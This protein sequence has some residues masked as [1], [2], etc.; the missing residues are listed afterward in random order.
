M[1]IV[2]EALL[3][4]KFEKEID[5]L[6][7]HLK[8][9]IERAINIYKN[10][11]IEELLDYNKNYELQEEFSSPFKSKWIKSIEYLTHLKR[12][13]NFGQFNIIKADLD[14][15]DNHLSHPKLNRDKTIIRSLIDEILKF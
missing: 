1:N 8:A 15:L 11:A 12:S 4:K 13:M 2:L 10:L 7:T 6:H 5:A 9:E 3:L 14:E